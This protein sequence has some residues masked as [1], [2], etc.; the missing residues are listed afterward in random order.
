MR[1]PAETLQLLITLHGQLQNLRMN[2]SC[3]E[4]QLN[5]LAQQTANEINS[6]DDETCDDPRCACQTFKK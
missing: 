3:L 2:L 5:E 4:E 1:N 6:E